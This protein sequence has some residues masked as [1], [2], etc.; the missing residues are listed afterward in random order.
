MFLDKIIRDLSDDDDNNDEIV[1]PFEDMQHSPNSQPNLHLM[2]QSI[3][4]KFLKIEQRLNRNSFS[5]EQ[6]QHHRHIL[7]RL[8]DKFY[9]NISNM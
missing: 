9:K 4:E 5:T 8:K 6:N 1:S 3:E 7:D 2:F